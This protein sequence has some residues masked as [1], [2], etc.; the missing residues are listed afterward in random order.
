MQ[1]IEKSYCAAGYLNRMSPIRR[2]F[3]VTPI[4]FRDASGYRV[5]LATLPKI[6]LRRRRS[7][8]TARS[9]PHSATMGEEIIA[10]MRARVEQCRQLAR[11]TTDSR[12]AEILTQMADEGDAEVVKLEAEEQNRSR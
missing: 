11:M 7:G 2:S 3:R 8:G 12:V 9:R 10:K 4:Q 5:V 1:D 6:R